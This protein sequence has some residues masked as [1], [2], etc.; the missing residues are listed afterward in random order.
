MNK[1]VVSHQKCSWIFT[2]KARSPN[3][4][5]NQSF[6][7]WTTLVDFAVKIVKMNKGKK[8]DRVDMGQTL[9]DLKNANKLTNGAIYKSIRELPVE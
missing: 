3:I 7:E 2:K 5:Q 6:Y 4:T 9:E 8:G 1:Y